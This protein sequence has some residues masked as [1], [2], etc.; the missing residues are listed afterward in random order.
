MTPSV[1]CPAPCQAPFAGFGNTERSVAEREAASVG[2]LRGQGTHAEPG[3]GEVRGVMSVHWEER[4]QG[5]TAS[6]EAVLVGWALFQ[7]SS[8]KVKA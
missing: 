5:G 7:R 8:G 3:D 6:M 2:H 1:Q 4:M